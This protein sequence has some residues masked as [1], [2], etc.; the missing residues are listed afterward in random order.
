MRL[1]PLKEED[2][3]NDPIQPM[4]KNIQK[5]QRV[6]EASQTCNICKIL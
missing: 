6:T 5:K 2:I 1:D 3:A 4:V